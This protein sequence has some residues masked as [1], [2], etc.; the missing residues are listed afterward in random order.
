MESKAPD[1]LFDNCL[2]LVEKWEVTARNKFV[3]AD[4]NKDDHSDSPTGK[5]LIEHGAMCYYNCAQD[6]REVLSS[7]LPS[8]STTQ[9][10]DQK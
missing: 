2:R 7:L 1:I 5:R 6:L 4:N 10:G 8:P 9:E 3:S